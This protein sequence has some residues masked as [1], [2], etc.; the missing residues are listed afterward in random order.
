MRHL[1]PISKVFMLVLLS[2]KG[3]YLMC[4]KLLGRTRELYLCTEVEKEKKLNLKKSDIQSSVKIF[5]SV[6]KMVVCTE[7]KN[8][9]FTSKKFKIV[10]CLFR[11][12][13]LPQIVVSD[14]LMYIKSIDVLSQTLADIR[15]NILKFGFRT[16]CH[17]L[18]AFFF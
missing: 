15:E 2:F 10:F 6:H 17:N 11:D 12:K 9:S 13:N 16:T 4:I 14:F 3:R 1:T 18:A 5:C 8:H 7:Q